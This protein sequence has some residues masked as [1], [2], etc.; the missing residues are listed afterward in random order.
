MVKNITII[1]EQVQSFKEYL[2]RNGYSRQAIPG[3]GYSVHIFLTRHPGADNFGYAQVLAYM[4]ELA[5]TDASISTLS[6]KLNAIKK[7]YDHL[8][9]CGKR[10]DHPCKR[11]FLKTKSKRNVIQNDLFTESELESLMDRKGHFNILKVKHQVVISLMIYQGLTP[12]EITRLKLHHVDLDSG[13]ILIRGA[14]QLSQ[15]RIEMHPRQYDLFDRYLH[16]DRKKLL[17]KGETGFFIV[18]LLG[19]TYKPESVVRCVETMKDRFPDRN[20]TAKSI[21][22]SVIS[23]LL[24]QRRFPLEQVQLFAGHRWVC[25]TQR[26]YQAPV[27]EEREVLRQFHPLG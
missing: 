16:H 21:R 7:Y 20:L 17:K 11:L 15:R 1:N 19:T 23:N 24:N 8:I 3:Y 22:D 2:I 10:D 25:S 26:Y 18:N 9:D 5:M 6:T 13:T 12:G 27:E 14:A 4:D